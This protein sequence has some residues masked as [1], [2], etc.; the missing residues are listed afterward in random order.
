MAVRRVAKIT[1]ELWDG[2]KESISFPPGE[3]DAIYDLEHHYDM[4]GSE[5]KGSWLR[6]SLKW[7]TDR[8]TIQK[9]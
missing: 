4:K 9:E 1:F 7:T 2:T 3:T 6:H 5:V 8:M